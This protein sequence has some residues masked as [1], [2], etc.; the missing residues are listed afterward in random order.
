MDI[1]LNASYLFG[2]VVPLVNI[3]ILATT[4]LGLASVGH[5]LANQ[6][7]PIDCSAAAS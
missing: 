2:F 7:V 3:I 4:L 5:T 1:S 6:S